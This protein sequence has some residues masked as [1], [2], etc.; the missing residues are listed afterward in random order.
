MGAGALSRDSVSAVEM[1]NRTQATTGSNRKERHHIMTKSPKLIA[2]LTGACSAATIA[3]LTLGGAPAYA[4]AHS[5]SSRTGASDTTTVSRQMPEI[6][7]FG[8]YYLPKVACPADYPYLLNQRYNGGSGFRL[9]PGVEIT[10][11]ERGMDVVALD[12]L[13][14]PYSVDPDGNQEYML[15]GISGLRDPI[16]NSATNWRLDKSSFTIVLHCTSDP[17]QGALTPAH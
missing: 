9:S 1:N 10:N 3:V 13:S 17:T 15:T 12:S 5:Q 6:P 4:A 11:Y 2:W 8:S 16:L 7:S 14:V